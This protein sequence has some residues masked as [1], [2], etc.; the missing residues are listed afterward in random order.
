M[1]EWY[2][3]SNAGEIDSPALLIF[4]ERVRENIS[5]AIRLS[6]GLDYLRPHV[7]THKMREVT[8]LMLGAGIYKFKCA[9]I[10]EAEMLALSGAPD[11]LLAYQPS[12]PKARRLARLSKN[13]PSVRFSCL[14]D[15]LRTMLMLSGVF[16]DQTLDIYLDL[17][18]GMNRTGLPPSQAGELYRES[19]GLKNIFIAGLHA[20]DGHIHDKDPE[21]RERRADEAFELAGLAKKE[22]ETLGGGDLAIV[23]GGTPTFP[24]HARRNGVETSPG[25][26]VF[27]DEGYRSLMPDLPFLPAAVLMT[28]VISKI[29]KHSL[30]L[31]LGHK[32]V[33]AENTLE[34]RVKFPGQP[35]AEAL[36]QSEEHL[37]MRL[38]DAGMHEIGDVWY[39]IPWHI[40]PTVALYDTV[41]IVEDGTCT[42]KWKVIARDRGVTPSG[43]FY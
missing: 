21:I 28:R 3:I 33:A 42:G 38:S 12:L 16:T 10:A 13:Y 18:V 26:F 40:C 32:S 36:S 27:W 19:R 22:I 8:E 11:I 24:V 29:D 2:D 20:Y 39:G 5:T 34:K 6:S 23:M 9:T 15:N 14:A 25:T 17:N 1:K 30:C 31:D 41:H 43:R 37:V 35:D 7:K 4:A